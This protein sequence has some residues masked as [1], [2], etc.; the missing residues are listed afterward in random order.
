LGQLIIEGLG[1]QEIVDHVWIDRENRRGLVEVGAIAFFGSPCWEVGYKTGCR[2]FTQLVMVCGLLEGPQK[3]D[4]LDRFV[5]VETV[6]RKDR[7]LDPF[8]VC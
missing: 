2:G 7:V 5:P 1:L 6:I 3:G 8:E 4:Y